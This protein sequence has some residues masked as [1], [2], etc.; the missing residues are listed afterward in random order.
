MYAPRL[1]V[2]RGKGTE[3]RDPEGVAPPIYIKAIATI[4]RW[5]GIALVHSEPRGRK[6][7]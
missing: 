7:R 5:W 1:V 6:A 2:A 4:T 3:W